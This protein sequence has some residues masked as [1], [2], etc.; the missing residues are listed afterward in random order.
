MSAP[1]YQYKFTDLNFRVWLHDQ[2]QILAFS[3]KK[4]IYSHFY[5]HIK[6]SFLISINAKFFEW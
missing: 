4:S 3:V 6:G 2:G 1:L 5:F